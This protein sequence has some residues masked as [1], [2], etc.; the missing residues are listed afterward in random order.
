M[1][2][3]LRD[4][5]T[6]FIKSGP[7]MWLFLLSISTSLRS[8]NIYWVVLFSVVVLSWLLAIPKQ[9]FDGVSLALIAFSI[10]YS[11]ILCLNGMVS[12]I[13]L[14]ISYIISPLAFY[15]F[16]KYV[17][18]R[19]CIK[20][21]VFAFLVFTCLFFSLDL[22]RTTIVDI[23][24][25]GFGNVLR[26]M[27]T[28][29][30]VEMAAT[31]YGVI[32][33]LCLSGV[34]VFIKPKEIRDYKWWLL[35]CMVALSLMT[36]LHLINRTGVVVIV[37]ILVC[38]LLLYSKGN[39]FKIIIPIVLCVLLLLL[40]MKFEV[41]PSTIFDAYTQRNEVGLDD[42]GDRSWRW[43]DAL[44]KLF[45]Y[46]FGW[47]NNQATFHAYVHNGWLDIARVAGVIP[48]L[49]FTIT[50]IV[51]FFK[52]WKLIKNNLRDFFVLVLVAINVAFFLTIFVE[53]II[54]GCCLYLYLY[55][56]LWGI[57]M[58]MLR[59]ISHNQD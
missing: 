21:L 34:I 38:V 55:C 43:I 54:E 14:L 46:P 19:F 45:I 39:I 59:R 13:F 5:N 2:T 33:S 44:E 27:A 41:V 32:A 58:E 12:S 20:D 57:E 49:I 7:L 25:N 53:P 9:K 11:A 16:G 50:N 15:I 23:S 4:F 56:M 40:L 36:V 17:V 8:S 30:D 52:T 22:F 48:F 35:A 24:T 6:I 29:D 51:I 31:L 3:L 37:A 47:S 42:A 26:Q 28:S 10:F 18:N 1:K